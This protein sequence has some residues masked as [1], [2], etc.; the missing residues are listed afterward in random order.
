M[1]RVL[2]RISCCLDYLLWACSREHRRKCLLDKIQC[3]EKCIK[4][5]E[6]EYPRILGYLSIKEGRK[7]KRACWKLHFAKRRLRKLKKKLER[8]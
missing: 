7:Y 6:E 4:E 3:I 5:I 2:I 1:R 8:K